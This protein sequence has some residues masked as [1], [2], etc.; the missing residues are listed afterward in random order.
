[1]SAGRIRP[2]LMQGNEA[3]AEGAIAA[4]MRFFGGYPISP[5]SEVAE[6][7]SRRLPQVGGTYAQME[8]EIASISSIIGASIAGVKSMTATSGPGYS[9]MQEGLGYAIISE[10]PCVVVNVQRVGP[11]TGVATAPAQGDLMQTRWGTHGPHSTIALSPSSVKECFDVAVKA[12][13]LAEKYRT[14]VVLLADAVIGHLRE[15]VTLPTP[16][17]IEVVNRES[18]RSGVCPF[19]P[20][21]NGVPAIPSFGMGYHFHVT[22]LFHDETGFPTEAAGVVQSNSDRLVNKIEA[23]RKEMTYV[24]Y[25]YMDDAEVA[26]VSYG[27]S[28]RTAKAA[29]RA[30]R[31]RGK[32]V[33]LVR[34]ITMWPFPQHVIKEVAQKAPRLVVVEMGLG[35][36]ADEIR[37]VTRNEVQVSEV[38][39]HDGFMITP[40]QVL[41]GI[42]GV[43]QHA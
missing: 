29:V 26:V 24:E 14:P 4:G 32:K 34:L 18:P 17:E 27:C 20:G 37:R 11:S 19:T 25:L 36:L 12:F 7:L 8:D 2:L 16:E 15:V 22:G 43:M 6:V 10:T 31:K 21:P 30:A 3:I 38:N 39:R 42:E 1:M 28:G 40:E 5:S 23:H 35:A 33:G 13:N 41:A 9:L